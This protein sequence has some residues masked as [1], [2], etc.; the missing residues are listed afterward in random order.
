MVLTLYAEPGNFRAFK[1][2][3]AAEY[4][5]VSVNIPEF[6]LNVDNTTPEFL[7]KSPLGRVP[8]LETCCGVITESNAIARYVARLRN[9]TGLYGRTFFESAKVDQWVDF[10][11]HNLELPATVWIYPLL[12]FTQAND[13]LTAKAKTDLAAGL[14]VIDEHLA[15]ATYLVGDHITL[16]DI[17]VATTLLYP[18]KFVC[19]ADFR[20]QF[21]NVMRWFDTCVHQPAFE[22][23]IGKVVLAAK[24]ATGSVTVTGPVKKG[25]DKPKVEKAEK[26]PKPPKEEKKKEPAPPK[27]PKEEKK[28]SKE[29]EEEDEA[30]KEKK[31]D[32][33]FKIMDAQS[34]TPFVMDAWKRCYS[35]C[36]GD[37]EGAMKTFW[38]TIDLKGWSIWRGDY[39]YNDE[40]KVLFMSSNLIGGFIQRTDEIRK[41]LFGTMT[42]RGVEKQGM[43]ITCYYLIRG[44]DIKPL[45]ACNDDA[46]C[47]VWT[48]ITE[49]G[50]CSEE[51][52][53][54]LF[55]YWT[56]DE[57]LEG[58]PVL[59]SRCY[60]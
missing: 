55:D 39:K 52:K 25:N 42:I 57:Q 60:K 48:N 54:L 43:K 46:E 17:T 34:P 28:P 23:V 33:I 40:L 32:H 20:N 41:W 24:E 7:K 5:G 36:H 6:K 18:F 3:I 56:T 27:A 14:K 12:G 58:E 50:V 47:Y 26:A 38:E 13:A 16:A 53:K 4:N 59:D 37:Y 49:G 44:H 31:E 9:D 19:T 10:C 8:V 29:E 11:S 21:P 30:P 1:I 51:N 2:L 22:A 35:N 45:I 15:T